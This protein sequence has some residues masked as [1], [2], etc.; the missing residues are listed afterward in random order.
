LKIASQLVQAR[1][2]LRFLC[3]A[4]TMGWLLWLVQKQLLRY[5]CLI[6]WMRMRM[7]M[8][9][10][11]QMLVGL[12]GMQVRMGV[13]LIGMG[14]M[15]L[16]LLWIMIARLMDRT[17]VMDNLNAVF[18]VTVALFL[19]VTDFFTVVFSVAAFA[20]TVRT[21]VILTIRLL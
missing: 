15:M 3:L 16:L 9:M 17:R 13:L 8:L 2:V 11:I 5:V 18:A 6:K 1:Q 19:Q 21:A 4:Q 14:I 20:V 10:L 7:R 12:L